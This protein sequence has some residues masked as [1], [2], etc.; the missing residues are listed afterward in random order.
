MT[1]KTTEKSLHS[2]KKTIW[3]NANSIFDDSDAIVQA[4]GDS[5]AYKVKSLIGQKSHFVQP[6]K[7]GGRFCVMANVLG[8]NQPKFVLTQ[9]Q[10]PLRLVMSVPLCAGIKSS[11][12]SQILP[13]WQRV[14]SQ[15]LQVKNLEKVQ[16]RRPQNTFTASLKMRVS[17]S[18]RIVHQ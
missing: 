3:T 10:L 2:L 11:N 17:C 12:V 5:T 8:T 13:L 14:V 4:P 6:S 15:L 1:T 9:L 18:S 7:T 16:Q